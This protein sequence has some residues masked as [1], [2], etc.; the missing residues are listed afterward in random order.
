[1]AKVFCSVTRDGNSSSKEGV[2]R[3]S[4]A[5]STDDNWLLRQETFSNIDWDEPFLATVSFGSE[6]SEEDAWQD[7]VGNGSPDNVRGFEDPCV[8]PE[9]SGIVRIVVFDKRALPRLRRDRVQY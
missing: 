2:D 9:S 3:C 6:V 5:E 4:P 1:M 7:L 8:R